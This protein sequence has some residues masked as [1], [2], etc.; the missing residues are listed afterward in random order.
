MDAFVVKDAPEALRHWPQWQWTLG[1][2]FSLI[3]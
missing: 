3:S 1:P 2:S